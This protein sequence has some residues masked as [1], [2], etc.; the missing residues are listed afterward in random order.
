M[1][2]CWGLFL[3][4][5]A[6]NDDLPLPRL[7]T[8]LCASFIDA[9]MAHLRER[10]LKSSVTKR[11]TK[12]SVI[13]AGQ[14]TSVSLEDEFWNSL[15]EIA[16]ERGMTHVELVAAIDDDHQHANL[17]SA[18]RL[19]VLSF[20]RA[21]RSECPTADPENSAASLVEPA[22]FPRFGSER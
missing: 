15:K 12:R 18:I 20:Y 11:S 14:K 22:N 1:R 10:S 16:S 8:K 7:C 2:T 19:F 6:P 4:T 17:S 13:I 5:L 3:G 21:Q 9:S